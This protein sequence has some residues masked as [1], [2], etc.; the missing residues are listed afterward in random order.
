MRYCDT[1]QEH[2]DIRPLLPLRIRFYI[3][4]AVDSEQWQA[5]FKGEPSI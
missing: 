5:S 3:I 2:S 1:L 4:S